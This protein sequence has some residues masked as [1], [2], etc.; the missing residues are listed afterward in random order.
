M[1]AISLWLPWA[2]LVAIKAKRFETRGRETLHRGLIA[3]HAAKHWSRYQQR[4]VGQR[5][6]AAHWEKRCAKG[7]VHED[8]CV[9]AVAK[10]AE[11]VPADKAREKL[12]LG[13]C[14][15]EL[16]FGDFSDGRFAWRFSVVVRLTEP[17][18]CVGRQWIWTL[19]IDVEM[20]I[21]AQV[22]SM[23]LTEI[24][25]LYNRQIT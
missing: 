24:K 2:H 16:Q 14:L 21:D 23:P 4:L 3:I 11:V 25:E 9:I 17:V 10:L 1:K 19:P 7:P 20:R 12:L 13:G 18:A 15:D 5:P 8:G 22:R 6:F